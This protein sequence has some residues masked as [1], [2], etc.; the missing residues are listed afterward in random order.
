MS[1]LVVVAFDD[2]DTADQFKAELEKLQKEHLLGLEDLVV[3]K[4]RPDGKVKVKQAVNL[5]GAGALSGSFWGLLIGMLFWAPWLGMAIGAAAG[6]LGGSLADYG[7]DDD[8]ID[9]VKESIPEGGSAVFMLISKVVPDKVEEA[10]S[11]YKG[12]VLKTS[13]SH[14]DE[15][16]LKEMFGDED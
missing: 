4:R 7:I 10:L 12:K 5:A 2:L 9:E 11:H 15:A 3:V 13:L 1:D 14:E 6:A 8:F 16:K